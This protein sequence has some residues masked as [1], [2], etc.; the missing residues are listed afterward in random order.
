MLQLLL[1]Y[2]QI[3]KYQI[4]YYILGFFAILDDV[5][6]RK[7]NQLSKL[8]IIKYI[9]QLIYIYYYFLLIN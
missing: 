6:N 5:R 2:F 1:A 9:I 7:H 8:I 4:L 3:I